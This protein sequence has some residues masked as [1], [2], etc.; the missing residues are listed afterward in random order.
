MSDPIEAAAKTLDFWLGY[1]QYHYRIARA[2]LERL[3]ADGPV[4]LY[5]GKVLE[6]SVARP[7]QQVWGYAFSVYALGEYVVA[8]LPERGDDE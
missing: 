6:H 8:R 3:S 2:M 4:V 5:D 7:R 1:N